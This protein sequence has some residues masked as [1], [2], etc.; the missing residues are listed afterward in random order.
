VT[1]P[2]DVDSRAEA[3]E[4]M[5]S[6]PDRP[7]PTAALPGAVERGEG[8]ARLGVRPVKSLCEDLEPQSARGRNT[9]P[10]EGAGPQPVRCRRCRSPQGG[11]AGS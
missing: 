3:G 5:K 2:P 6:R 8:G 10:P 11:R 1:L 9:L 4:R 7:G